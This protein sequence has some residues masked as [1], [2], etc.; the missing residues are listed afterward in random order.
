VA[1]HQLPGK[2]GFAIDDG[3]AFGLSDVPVDVRFVASCSVD[4]P[5]FHVALGGARH[6]RLGPFRPGALVDV[7]AGLALGFLRLRTGRE[8]HI[9]RMRDLVGADGVSAIA[10]EVG[11][12][13]RV[14]P[15][16]EVPLSAIIGAHTLGSAGFLGVGL[17]FG[18][19]TAEAFAELASAA[20]ASGAQELRLTPWRAILVPV[21]SVSAARRLSAGLTGASFI[22]GPEDPRLRIAACPGA[23]SCVRATTSVRADADK[24]AAN[25]SGLPG[26]GIAV[27][28][29]G[30]EK[31][32]AHPRAAAVTLVG[33]A[34]R[35]DLVVKGNAAGSP[36][37]L[38]L[39]ADE[40]AMWVNPPAQGGDA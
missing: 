17:P 40:A 27:H 9:R 34:G 38:G 36:A 21:P 33:R 6:D 28:V 13:H 19:V 12:V 18:R 35:Y 29:S 14:V 7:A 25:I 22:L 20:S 15:L 32:C 3:G 39:T 31:G 30:C 8:R 37:L 26:A 23:P 4:G 2:F 5:V 16:A 24:L 1:L 11:L 10:R